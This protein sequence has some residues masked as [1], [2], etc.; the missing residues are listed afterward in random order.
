MAACYN[1]PMKLPK[2]AVAGIKKW[3]ERPVPYDHIGKYMTKSDGTGTKVLDVGCGD[4][5][6]YSTY[7]YYPNVEYSGIDYRQVPGISDMHA[8]YQ[9]NIDGNDLADVPNNEYDVIILSHII[10]HV[11][12]GT[13]LLAIL[14]QKLKS[15]GIIYIE[16]PSERSLHL[17]HYYGTLNFYD[18][19]THTRVYSLAEMNEVLKQN[20]CKILKSRIRHNFK[21][22]IFLPLYAIFMLA[23][24]KKISATLFWDVLGFAHFVVAQKN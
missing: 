19:S 15:G 16:T 12:N 8:F 2:Q 13:K 11:H 17:P 23:R 9:Y 10:E 4:R 20:G 5:A 22:I 6:P 3:F 14:A 1:M 7:K 18:D 21:K 24:D